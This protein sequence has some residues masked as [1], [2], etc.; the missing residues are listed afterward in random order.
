V[1]AIFYNE[2]KRMEDHVKT[3][4]EV[5]EEIAQFLVVLSIVSCFVLVGAAVYAVKEVDNHF[6]KA[7][8]DKNKR[9]FIQQV[10][11]WFDVMGKP[12]DE[13]E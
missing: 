3:P 7:K 11:D 8:I 1:K 12:K 13:S 6:H 10:S 9:E 2:E 4:Q 5:D